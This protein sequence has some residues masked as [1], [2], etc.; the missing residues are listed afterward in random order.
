MIDRFLQGEF[1]LK[2]WKPFLWIAILGCLFYSQTLFFDFTYLDDNTLILNNQAFLSDFSNIGEAFRT[3]V[4]H[5]FNHSAFYYRPLLTISFMLD[6]QIGGTAPFAYHF[7]NLVFH[8]LAACLLFVFLKNLR[9]RRDISFLLSL[10]Y[11]SH[12]VLTQAVAW[13]PGRNDSLLA[14]FILSAFIFFIQFL[15]RGQL[16]CFVFHLLF[17]ALAIFTKETALFVVPLFVFFFYFL[18]LSKKN[19]PKLNIL[20]GWT[21]VLGLWFFLRSLIPN[22]S[23][24]LVSAEMIK[25]VLINLLAVIQLIGK[26]IFPFNLSV[27]PII[28]DTSFVYGIVAL[29]LITSLFFLKK[30]KRWNYLLFGLGWF[31]LFLLPSFLKLNPGSV[32]DFIEHRL[33]LPIIGLLI[34]LLELNPIK[35]WRK[36]KLY[37]YSFLIVVGMFG[38]LAFL[39]SFNF[40]DRL[41]FWQNAVETSPHHPLTHRNLGAMLYLE[42]DMVNAEIEFKESL[43]LNP[44]EEMAHNN[45]GLVYSN[46]GRLEESEMEY[47]KELEIN[48]FYDNAYFNLGLLYYRKGQIEEAETAWKTALEINPDNLDAIYCLLNLY[49][50]RGDEDNFLIYTNELYQRGI[51]AQ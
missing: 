39:H 42:G 24:F 26:S 11:L 36:N 30:E 47:K 35:N 25:S 12:P 50:E 22:S 45:L 27:L 31:F 28:Q 5:I 48:P 6:Y 38:S 37:Y 32:V 7:S 46:L 34:V 21:G 17:F 18:N 9:Y 10:V 33:Y 23:V 16:K 13:V 49:R 8:I 14:I 4:F 51:I 1:Y 40:S 15:R 43:K 29:G 20:I 41:V 3:D 44:N 2:G 19:V